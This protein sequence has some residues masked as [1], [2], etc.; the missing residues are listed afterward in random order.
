MEALVTR[1]PGTVDADAVG[2]EAQSALRFLNAIFEELERGPARAGAEACA[3]WAEGFAGLS[4]LFPRPRVAPKCSR[5]SQRRSPGSGKRRRHPRP[6]AR[7]C[8]SSGRTRRCRP[9]IPRRPGAGGMPAVPTSARSSWT[10]AIQVVLATSSVR[11]RAS[12]ADPI[13]ARAPAERRALALQ[14][15]RAGGRARRFEQAAARPCGGGRAPLRAHRGQPC[16]PV[17][18]RRAVCGAVS[19]PVSPDGAAERDARG[20]EARPDSEAWLDPCWWRP[21]MPA[22][23]SAPPPSSGAAGSRSPIPRGSSPATTRSCCHSCPTTTRTSGR[24]R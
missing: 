5:G 19:G 2:L 18:G 11:W 24:V 1:S 21:A 17:P 4:R 13:R 9:G 6:W 15:A 16:A 8:E 10:K 23:P 14:R 7:S 22:A 20:G 12:R 3:R